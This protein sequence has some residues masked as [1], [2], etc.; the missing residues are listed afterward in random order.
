MHISEADWKVYKRLRDLAQARYS[1][2]L[3]DEAERLCRDASLAA[4]DRHR[5]LSRL[6][7]ARDKEMFQIFETLRRSSAVRC[8]M[9]MRSYNL[10]TDAEMQAFSP[11]VQRASEVP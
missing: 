8:L 1:Q 5:A 9:M 3:L 6:V 2:R 4:Q 7:R 10:I 11:E